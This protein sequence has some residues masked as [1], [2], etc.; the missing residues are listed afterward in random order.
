MMGSASWQQPDAAILIMVGAADAAQ[1]G[2]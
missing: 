1:G 2:R